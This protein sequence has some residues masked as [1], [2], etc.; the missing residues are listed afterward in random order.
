D[1]RNAYQA[2]Y[3]YTGRS[4]SDVDPKWTTWNLATIDDNRLLAPGQGFFVK[5]QVNGGNIQFTPSMRSIGNSDD[6]I[7]NRP[8]NSKKELSKLLLSSAG[9]HSETSIYFI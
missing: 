1:S 9:K 8:T 4:D 5:S 6:F 2:I 3:G 7:P